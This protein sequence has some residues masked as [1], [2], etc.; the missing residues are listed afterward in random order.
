MDVEISYKSPLNWQH[1]LHFFGTRAI[2]PVE[3]VHSDS[4]SRTLSIDGNSG[5]LKI[6]HNP[7]QQ[8]LSVEIP[9]SLTNSTTNIV[10]TVGRVFD[11]EADSKAISG[12]LNK[13]PSIGK[14][15]KKYPGIRL[16]GAWSWFEIA[17]RAVLGQQITV[18]AARTIAGRIVQKF[19]TAIGTEARL[20]PTAEQI[21]DAP[22]NGFGI[23][24]RRAETLR[25]LAKAT[26]EKQ[27][28]EPGLPLEEIIRRFCDLPG[29]GPWTAHYIALRAFGETDVFLPRDVGLRK[30]AARLIGK[31]LTDIELIKYAER[32]RPWR[33]YAVLYLWASLAD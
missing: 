12:I 31:E 32:W 15:V 33:S 28:P 4:Y 26:V 13:D 3:W 29:I 14:V 21:L 16:P 8:S 5:I 22:L 23:P 7:D 9:A 27:I 25:M 30:A 19:G 17:M 24:A 2:E 1:T 20:F 6:R 11:L 10:R 18:R